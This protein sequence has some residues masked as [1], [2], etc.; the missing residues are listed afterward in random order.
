VTSIA[1]RQLYGFHNGFGTVALFKNV[2][3]IA[4]STS[5]VL[6][7]ADTDS[8]IVRAVD[9]AGFCPDGSYS[10][11]LSNPNCTVAPAGYYKP[12]ISFSDNYYMCAAGLVEKTV[13]LRVGW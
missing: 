10:T 4:I 5:G 6:Y 8:S 3:Q 1:G 7:V 11:T 2:L 12:K 9:T 13:C